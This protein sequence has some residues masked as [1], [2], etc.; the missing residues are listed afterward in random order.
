MTE[1]DKPMATPEFGGRNIA[2][3]S[4]DELL[5]LRFMIDYS[6]QPSQNTTEDQH[7]VEATSPING[8]N[9]L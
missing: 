5:L 4:L 7:R 3:L 2:D 1:N 9:E 6:N 8:C